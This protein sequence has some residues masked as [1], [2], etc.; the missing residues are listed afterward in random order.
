MK[1]IF[2]FLVGFMCVLA[3]NAQKSG[4]MVADFDNV[5]PYDVGVWGGLALDYTTAPAGSLA[6]GQMLVVFV[7]AGNGSGGSFTIT[8]GDMTFDP[9]EYVGVSFDCQ[10]SDA[11]EDVKFVLKLQQT[12]DPGHT[13]APLED[14][15]NWTPYTVGGEWQE[16]QIPFAKVISILDG[17]PDV[18]AD[19]Y[20]QIEL[21]PAGW[22][23]NP[24][25]HL[26]MDNFMLRYDWDKTGIPLTKAAALILKA[27]NGTISAIGNSNPVSLKVY[28][29]AGQEIAN[30]VNAVTVGAKGVYVVKALTGNASIV[31]KIV[32]R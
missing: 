24:D 25:I 21:L 16:V 17:K 1:R 31:Q 3:L 10:S 30:G 13:S 20:D 18:P 8:L 19:Q 23:G 4:T 6:S 27:E 28:S 14:W 22:S 26:N 9:H 29:P 15:D 7:P 12:A 5:V 11:T 32:V 2:T